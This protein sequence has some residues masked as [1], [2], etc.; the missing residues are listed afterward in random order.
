MKLLLIAFFFSSLVCAN[1]Q[2]DKL[3]ADRG[4][5]H[6]NAKLAAIAYEKTS[7]SLA[8]IYARNEARVNASRAY[9]IYAFGPVSKD[10]SKKYY[11]LGYLVG[12][13][14]ADE[15][16]PLNHPEL[17]AMA[18]FNYSINLGSWAKLK[19]IAASAK[20]W[21]VL[22]KNMD[23][24]INDLNKPEV[25]FFGADRF[26]GKALLEVPGFLGG[27]KS[28]ALL[29]AKKAYENT[30]NADGV[31]VHG[32]NNFHYAE[33][34]VKNKDKAKAKEIL[35]KFVQYID[36]HGLKSLNPTRVPE[37][38]TEYEWSKDLLKKL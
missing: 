19:G 11:E 4:I 16:T 26:L 9:F 3:Y 24:I 29:H 8:D 20:Y 30:L 28:K 31:S 36:T 17:L 15:L 6:N 7:T 14:A 33:A 22:K 1:I 23:I 13:L 2:N 32:A 5:D 25:E 34:L 21:P 35:S 38:K 27:S 18:L 10:E 37:T 12:K